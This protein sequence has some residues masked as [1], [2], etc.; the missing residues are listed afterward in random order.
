MVVVGCEKCD[1]D[2]LSR[3][4]TLWDGMRWTELQYWLPLTCMIVFLKSEL[5]RNLFFFCAFIIMI[6]DACHQ[7]G[8][9]L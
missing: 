3:Y 4:N 7:E 8:S 6:Q 1:V 2:I 9:L 5:H